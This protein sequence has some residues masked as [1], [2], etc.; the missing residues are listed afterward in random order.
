MEDVLSVCE[1]PY[2]PVRPLVCMDEISVQLLDYVKGREPMGVQPGH[3]A[4]QDYE[5]K[6]GARL[7]TSWISSLWWESATPRHTATH[8]D[9]LGAL[10]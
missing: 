5:Y 1:R 8:Q 2:D 4:K 7:T 6:R 3:T 9:K 10:G